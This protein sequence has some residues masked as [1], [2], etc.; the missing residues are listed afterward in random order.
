MIFLEKYLLFLHIYTSVSLPV[1]RSLD[2]LIASPVTQ[3]HRQACMSAIYYLCLCTCAERE[4]PK[5]VR[6]T[7]R[8]I[9]NKIYGR[10]LTNV[11][12]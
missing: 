2:E 12:K 11:V 5:S 1:D 7:A 8:Q 9:Q 4:Y 10:V 3:A 6:R